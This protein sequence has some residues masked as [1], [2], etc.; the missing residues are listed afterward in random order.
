[1]PFEEKGAGETDILRTVEQNESQIQVLSVAGSEK[2]QVPSASWGRQ[3]VL[4]ER[5]R[6]RRMEHQDRRWDEEAVNDVIGVP[7]ETC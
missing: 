2:Q 4:S 1:M 7:V 5:E 3:K 6:F